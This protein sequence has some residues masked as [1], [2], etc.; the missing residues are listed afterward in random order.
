MK[1]S[2]P[3]KLFYEGGGPTEPNAQFG[4]SICYETMPPPSPPPILGMAER[5]QIAV[6]SQ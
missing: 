6:A 3:P 1:A 5:D 2:D 4:L